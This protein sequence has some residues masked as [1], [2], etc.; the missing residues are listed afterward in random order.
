[1]TSVPPS[2]RARVLARSFAVQ[3]SWNYETLIGSGFAFTLLPALRF[4]YGATGERLEEAVSRHAEL[5]NSHPYLATVAAGAVARLE[6][7]AADPVVIDRFKMALRGPLGAMGDRLVWTTWR[8]MTLLVGMVLYLAGIT[9]WMAVLAFL[10][11]YNALHLA[12]RVFGLR[13][14]FTS[15]LEVGRVLREA[16]LQ[17]VIERASQVACV[18]IGLAV[19]LAAGPVVHDPGSLAV[20]VLAAGLGIALGLR[21]RRII[22]LLVLGITIVSIGLG[23]VGNGA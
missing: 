12:V 15:G 8:P 19:V 1:M 22:F 18:L 10:A 20:L 14:G 3:G 4:L 11:S 9:W 2:V 17:P 7:E 16:P 5:F 13:I 6:A 21:S 23:F